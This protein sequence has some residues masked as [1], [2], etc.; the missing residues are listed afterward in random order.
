MTAHM[1]EG[2]TPEQVREV[3]VMTEDRQA[4]QRRGRHLS[5]ELHGLS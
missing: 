4:H 5:R 2:R 3:W 1:D